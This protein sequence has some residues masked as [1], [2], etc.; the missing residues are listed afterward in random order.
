MEYL[1]FWRSIRKVYKVIVMPGFVYPVT[2]EGKSLLIL[3]SILN[4]SKPLY[5]AS[6]LIYKTGISMES[7][8]NLKV[9]SFT[10]KINEKEE[11]NFLYKNP[12]LNDKNSLLTFYFE[13]ATFCTEL[14]TLMEGKVDSDDLFPD[15]FKVLKYLQNQY[16]ILSST[17]FKGQDKLSYLVFRKTFIYNYLRDH[18]HLPVKFNSKKQAADYLGLSLSQFDELALKGG[19]SNESN[20]EVFKSLFDE[21]NSSL[22]LSEREILKLSE[23]GTLSKENELKLLGQLEILYAGLTKLEDMRLSALISSGKN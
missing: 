1:I 3:E 2:D 13:D 21:M 20:Y 11:V 9:S 15:T 5:V 6:Y 12:D 10:K 14:Q 7:V 16:S 19:S 23:N 18:G 8:V 4:K 17:V 22:S